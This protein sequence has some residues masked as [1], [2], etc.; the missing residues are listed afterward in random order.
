MIPCYA[1]AIPTKLFDT[2]WTNAPI[3]V[4]P[5]RADPFRLAIQRGLQNALPA[6]AI[7]S[8]VLLPPSKQDPYCALQTDFHPDSPPPWVPPHRWVLCP[9]RT[10]AFPHI[11]N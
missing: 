2:I 7:S 10:V 4:P 8:L 9:L 11:I 1:T 3:C 5:I 6:T